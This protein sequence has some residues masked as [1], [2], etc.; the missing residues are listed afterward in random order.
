MKFKIFKFKNVTSTNDVAINLIKED[1]KETGC[2]YAEIQTKGRGTR[3]RRWISQKGNFFGSIFFPLK[4]DY[5]PFNEFT[6]INPVIISGVME[7]FCEKKN[8]SFKWPNDVF[9][10]G[11]K[12]CGILQ[13]LIT[14]NNKKFLIIGI[15][16]NIVSSPNINAKYETTNIFLETRKIPSIKKII[17][18]IIFSYEKFFLNLNSYNYNNFKKEADLMAFI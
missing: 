2:I 16:I 14:L 5:P 7:N 3:G 10:N 17:N 8:I 15:G 4:N 18:Q 1:K 11:K 13:E 6:I 9:L 12:I